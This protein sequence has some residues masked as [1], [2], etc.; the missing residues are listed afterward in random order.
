MPRGLAGRRISGPAYGAR[1]AIPGSV[2]AR[3]GALNRHRRRQ[4]YICPY[5]TVSPYGYA[6]WLGGYDPYLFGS[7]DES[8]QGRAP[9]QN[10][11]AAGPPAETDQQPSG[12]D[13]PM[14]RFPYQPSASRAPAASNEEAVT[15]IFK[16][17]RPPEQIH[18]YLLTPT[19]LYVQDQNRRSIPV[20]QLDIAATEKTNQDA[21]V[22]F[23]LPRL[24]N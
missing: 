21:G 19:I 11:A 5:G 23:Q 6:P 7:Q 2:A 10:D 12:P 9:A 13:Q 4:P 15:L 22:A 20:D 18:N 17:G 14:P 8:D 3:A 1:R 16:D 24:A